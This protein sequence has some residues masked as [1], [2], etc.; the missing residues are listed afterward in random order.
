MAKG[1]I[2]F[3]IKAKEVVV[4]RFTYVNTYVFGEIIP[5]V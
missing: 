3:R 4:T 2:K 1:Q 5:F